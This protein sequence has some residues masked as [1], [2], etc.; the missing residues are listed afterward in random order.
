M[1]HT[2]P[3]GKQNCLQSIFKQLAHSVPAPDFR[4]FVALLL[5]ITGSGVF[6]W[7]IGQRWP[8]SRGVYPADSGRCAATNN[9]RFFVY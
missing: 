6:F 4:Y 1:L 2:H 7:P 8:E 5:A 3:C 9:C